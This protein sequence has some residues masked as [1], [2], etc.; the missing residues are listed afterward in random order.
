MKRHPVAAYKI[1]AVAVSTA[2]CTAPSR[3]APEVVQAP[4]T[5]GAPQTADRGP[6]TADRGPQT[7]DRG[8]QTA[9][10]GPQTADREQRTAN[11][12]L[13]TPELVALTTELE[14]EGT[15]ALKRKAHYRP[16]CDRDGYPLVGNVMR[17][18]PPVALQP[19]ELCAAIR[20]KAGG[21]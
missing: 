2:A 16:L 10:R 4:T 7:A 17:K 8:P 21:R 5:D 20:A 6:Q 1:L 3:P 11:S 18:G 9:D 19:S 13:G 14:H 12:G 15:A